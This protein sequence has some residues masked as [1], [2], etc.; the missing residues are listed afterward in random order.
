MEQRYAA[1]CGEVMIHILLFI[2]VVSQAVT[3]GRMQPRVPEPTSCQFDIVSATVVMV[4]CGHRAGDDEILDVLIAWR[5]KPG[6]FQRRLG[7]G[8][9]GGGGRRTFPVGI[10]GQA[11]TGLKGNVSQYAIYNDITT[12]FDADFDAG[13]LVVDGATVELKGLNAIFIDEVERAVP[14][15][16][17][18]TAWI[19][20]S[21]PLGGDANLILARR[22]RELRDFLQCEVAI[23]QASMPQPP[24]ITVC[25]KLQQR[26]KR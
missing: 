16:I 3:A 2:G 9:S 25:E 10:N 12:S 1:G 13:I 20:P 8:R 7:A 22:S 24:V 21:I 14:R 19:E 17:S 6:W 5:G 15:R 23:P 4:N 26:P 18:Q 11:R